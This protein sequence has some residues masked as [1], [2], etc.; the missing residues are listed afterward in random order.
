MKQNIKKLAAIMIAGLQLA[1]TNTAKA[2][3]VFSSTS[4]L[5]FASEIFLILAIRFILIFFPS[6]EIW[7][8]SPLPLAVIISEGI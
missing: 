4:S 3:A 6:T 1:N 8:L 7:G 5:R 2:Q